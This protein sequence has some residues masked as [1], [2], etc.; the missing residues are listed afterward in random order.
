MMDGFDSLLEDIKEQMEEYIEELEK[1]LRERTKAG[2]EITDGWNGYEITIA[3]HRITAE[4]DSSWHKWRFSFNYSAFFEI[5]EKKGEAIISF[6]FALQDAIKSSQDRKAWDEENIAEDRSEDSFV[7][8]GADP[9][10]EG[11]E[12]IGGVPIDLDKSPSDDEVF[13][14]GDES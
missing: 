1:E 8:G 2:V 12:I 4:H 7:P 5:S 10:A 13:Y 11:E 6:L 9:A 14:L 3:G